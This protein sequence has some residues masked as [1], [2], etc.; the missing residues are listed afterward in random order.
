MEENEK[1]KKKAIGMLWIETQK[2]YMKEKL[3]MKLIYT[4][5]ERL[6]ENDEIKISG[7]KSQTNE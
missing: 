3:R 1:C 5:K 4:K 6:V 7:A 2:I